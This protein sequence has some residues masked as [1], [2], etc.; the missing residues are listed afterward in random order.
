MIKLAIIWYIIINI[1]L[2]SLMGIDKYKAIHKRW[3]IP[4]ATLLTCSAIGGV[5]GGFAGMHFF[6]HKTRKWYFHAVFWLSL[7][8]HIAVVCMVIKFYY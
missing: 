1:V 5:I 4:E 8:V 7:I 6:H 2:F 3:R